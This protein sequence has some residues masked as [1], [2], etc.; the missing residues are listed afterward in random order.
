[1]TTCNNSRHDYPFI[2]GPPGEVPHT[3]ICPA[4]GQVTLVP[5]TPIKLSPY[6]EACR[7]DIKKVIDFG[8]SP[9][10]KLLASVEQ[11]PKLCSHI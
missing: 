11:P 8:M 10:G 5:C 4:C 6:Q 1:M 3:H 2:S 7:Q 9:I